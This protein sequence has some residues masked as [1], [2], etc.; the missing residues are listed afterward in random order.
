MSNDWWTRSG[1][2]HCHTAAFKWSGSREPDRSGYSRYSANGLYALTR[3][4]AW[5]KLKS[6][7]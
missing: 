2:S 5:K 4:L 3:L 1:G 6:P 7:G